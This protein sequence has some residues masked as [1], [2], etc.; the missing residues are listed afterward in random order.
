MMKLAM[1]I[2]PLI[3]IGISYL[4]YRWKY[5]IDEPT[6]ADILRSGRREIGK[7]GG[8]PMSYGLRST[9]REVRASGGARRAKQSRHAAGD[10]RGWL[11]GRCWGA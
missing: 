7:P 5:K 10:W 11:P 8:G 6:H 3:L 4:I 1:M 9:L 2:L